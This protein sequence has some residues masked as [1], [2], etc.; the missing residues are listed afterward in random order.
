MTL[1][2][3]GTEADLSPERRLKTTQWNKIGR[4]LLLAQHKVMKQ[5]GY[6][7][8]KTNDGTYM[9]QDQFG[10]RPRARAECEAEVEKA[11]M[12]SHFKKVLTKHRLE[13]AEPPPDID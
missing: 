3:S 10:R 7:V 8:M 9:F 11:E 13:K 4:F 2:R 6:T 12:E 1:F 5:A